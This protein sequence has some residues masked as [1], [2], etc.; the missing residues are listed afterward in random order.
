MSGGNQTIATGGTPAPVVAGIVLTGAPQTGTVTCNGTTFTLNA[1]AGVA[2]VPP[3]IIPASSFWSQLT[4]IGL[5]AALGG[6]FVATR[7]NA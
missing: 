4:L 2:F 3:S 7:R 1:P 6:L 5:L